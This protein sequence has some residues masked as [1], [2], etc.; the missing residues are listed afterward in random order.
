MLSSSRRYPDLL[1]KLLYCIFQQDCCKKRVYIYICVVQQLRQQCFSADTGVYIHRGQY[2]P[3]F[4][5]SKKYIFLKYFSPNIKMLPARYF[6]S[7]NGNISVCLKYP[8]SRGLN[9][10]PTQESTAQ[11]FIPLFLLQICTFYIHIC[12]FRFEKKLGID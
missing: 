3:T 2:T 6:P 8:A 5:I 4:T 7:V 1:I 11:L 10:D 9:R 12:Q